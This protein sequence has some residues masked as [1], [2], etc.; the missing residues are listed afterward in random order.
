MMQTAHS[1]AQGWHFIATQKICR[2]YIVLIDTG[3]CENTS[4]GDTMLMNYIF[5]N[6]MHSVVGKRKNFLSPRAHG[7]LHGGKALKTV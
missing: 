4:D 2:R 6:S 3:G 7:K 1:L 5:N